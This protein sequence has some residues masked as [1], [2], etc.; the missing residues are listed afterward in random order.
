VAAHFPKQVS[1][2]GKDKLGA[3]LFSGKTFCCNTTDNCTTS[4]QLNVV[5][6][7]MMNE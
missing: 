6:V 7:G 4:I 3:A 1:H 5:A 2:W